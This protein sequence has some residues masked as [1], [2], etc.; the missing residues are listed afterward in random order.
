MSN[1]NQV[2][3]AEPEDVSTLLLMIRALA[4]YEKLTDHAQ[5]TEAL[6]HEHL[7]GAR[8]AAEALIGLIDGKP[9]GFA[10]FFTTFSTFVGKPGVWL[11]DL[12]VAPEARGQGL[13][14]MLLLTVAGITHARGCGR[15]EWSVLDWNK[16]SIDFYTRLGAV[17][18]NDWTTYR[19]AGETLAQLAEL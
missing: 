10:L 18:M 2:R 1:H 16:P 9:L 12:F 6:L 4:E 17:P 3:D 11:E 7:F 19:V 14:K 5:A 15:L 13:G 8:P